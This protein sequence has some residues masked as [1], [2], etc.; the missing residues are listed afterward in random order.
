MKQSSITSL[1]LK[2]SLGLVGCLS[3]FGGTVGILVIFGFLTFLWFGHGSNPEARNA[4]S[5]WRL[6][7]LRGWMT[8]TIT[9]TSLFLRLTISIQATV[10]TSMI[11]ALVL[12][13]RSVRKSDSA[14]F[15]IVRGINDGLF[16]L[17]KTLWSSRSRDIFVNSELWFAFILTVVTLA[18][19]FS[20]TVLLSDMHSLLVVGDMESANVNNLLLAP[21]DSTAVNSGVEMTAWTP[22]YTTFGEVQSNTSKSIP[23]ALGFSDSGL[24]QRGLLPFPETANRI[25]VRSFEGNTM[26][27][28]SRV[29][30]M[31]PVMKPV[32][33][34]VWL[35]M[36]DYTYGGVQ[37]ILD[38]QTS[39]QNATDGASSISCEST[40]CQK[41]AFKCKLPTTPDD[42]GHEKSS[43]CWIAPLG[44]YPLSQDTLWTPLESPWV[45]NSS[46]YLTFRSVMNSDDWISLTEPRT[47]E[48]GIPLQ[49]WNTYNIRNG[50]TVRASLCFSAFRMERQ[51]VRMTTSKALWEPTVNWTLTSSK[52]DT[53]KLRKFLDVDAKSYALEERG[54]LDMTIMGPADD[55][56]SSSPANEIFADL[57]AYGQNLTR[58]GETE[59]I[60]DEL[61]YEG[62]TSGWTPNNSYSACRDCLMFTAVIHSESSSLWEDIMTSTGRAVDALQSYKAVMAFKVFE[63][64][65]PSLSQTE[66]VQMAT[67]KLVQVPGPCNKHGCPGFIS[68]TVLLAIHLL[69]V[70]VITGLYA[71]QIRYSRHRNIWHTVS[72][73]VSHETAE[74]VEVANNRG[75]EAA[76]TVIGKKAMGNLVRLNRVSNEGEIGVARIK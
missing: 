53:S 23:N 58:A 21:Y 48:A 54:I 30:C 8:R 35:G 55:G 73:L 24:L 9:L 5:L 3:V 70:A 22:V 12:E 20:S 10:C 17:C 44:G 76:F 6:L 57:D 25:A 29:V 71:G 72:Q 37:G 52:R 51:N 36:T 74:I 16:R 45:Q 33:G 66:E 26:V 56:P 75:D 7:A 60:F 62:L 38:L 18:L 2:D 65:M 64:F 59:A 50:A 14:Y 27:M 19:Q 39:L 40:G 42:D 68:V 31:R 11:A 46:I 1:P 13:K 47:V 67:T 49:E 15:S 69:S 41:V 61:F 63:N 28:N 34:A 43:F 4:T 32:F